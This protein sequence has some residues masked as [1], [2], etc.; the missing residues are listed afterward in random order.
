MPPEVKIVRISSL[1]QRDIVEITDSYDLISIDLGNRFRGSL[2]A[3]LEHIEGFPE[4]SPTM[5]NGKGLRFCRLRKFP[6]L[7]LYLIDP[8]FV[9]IAGVY[10]QS[11]DRPWR[12][13][14]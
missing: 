13:R 12:D 6:Y 2:R 11:R 7:V 10:H 8:D 1:A 14:V 9:E 3:A 4:A 5:P